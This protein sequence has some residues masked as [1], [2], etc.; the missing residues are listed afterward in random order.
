M[1]LGFVAGLAV[2][3]PRTPPIV[4]GVGFAGGYT[5]FAT[6]VWES[7]ALTEDRALGEA[8]A[9]LVGSFAAGLAA[10]TAGLGLAML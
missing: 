2:H 8:A 7:L 10:G 5:T 9:N 3:L 4:T 1:L 6:W